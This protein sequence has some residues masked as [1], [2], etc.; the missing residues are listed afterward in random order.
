MSEWPR[1]DFTAPECRDEQVAKL[2]GLTG[3]QEFIG[4][5]EA[6]IA[7]EMGEAVDH[8]V[9]LEAGDVDQEGFVNFRVTHGR[10]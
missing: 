9:A 3:S 4:K 5:I 10:S 8:G 6:E 7:G 1:F 2:V